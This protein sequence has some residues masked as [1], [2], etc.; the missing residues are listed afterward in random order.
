MKPRLAAIAALCLLPRLV[1]LTITQTVTAQA[2][3]FFPPSNTSFGPQFFNL[4]AGSGGLQSVSFTAVFSFDFGVTFGNM[5]DTPYLYTPGALAFGTFALADFNTGFYS[6]GFS[7]NKNMASVLLQPRQNNGSRLQFST[8]VTHNM[9]QAELAKFNG[10]GT[11]FIIGKMNAFPN[12]QW[13]VMNGVE[14]AN[15][16]LTYIAADT[17]PAPG[18]SVATFP[19]AGHSALLLAGAMGLLFHFKARL[20][21]P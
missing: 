16:T 18:P 12:D 6:D 2:S 10:Q 5:F 13:A 17:N 19:D 20:K 9:T 15:F 8:T 4:Y 14:T 11:G 1:A 21:R 3:L 7:A